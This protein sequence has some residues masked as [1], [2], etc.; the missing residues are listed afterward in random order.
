MLSSNSQLERRQS[1]PS[2]SNEATCL[3][4]SQCCRLLRLPSR[5]SARTRVPGFS[6]MWTTKTTKQ[7]TTTTTSTTT[8][9]CWQNKLGCK[10][11]SCLTVST[12]TLVQSSVTR[13]AVDV[14][15]NSRQR[16]DHLGWSH[17]R[18]ARG[19]TPPHPGWWCRSPPS[20]SQQP[21]L[22]NV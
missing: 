1:L 16:L 13:R 22:S 15:F 18:Y 3:R 21:L 9:L 14:S 11:V 4:R 6:L 7:N 2:A 10:D 5:H 12:V 19:C 20:W 17:P 8:L